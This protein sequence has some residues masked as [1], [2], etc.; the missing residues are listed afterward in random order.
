[1]L[2]EHR[3]REFAAA[4]HL[5]G[6]RAVGR[7]HADRHVAD[8][9]AVQTVLDHAG[10]ELVVLALR[11]GQRGVVDAEGHRDGRLVHV[12]Q[13]QR[14]RVGRVDDRL[15]DHDVVHAGDGHDV[16]GTG[17]L[18]REAVQTLGAQ[19]LGELEVLD[20]A[21]HT[22]QAVLLALDERAVVD[23]DQTQSAQVVRGVDVGHMGLQ[24]GALLVFG[25]GDVRDDRIEQRFQVVVVRQPAV[26]RLVRGGVAG[27]GGAV[28]HRQ[29]QQRVEVQVHAL[30]DHVLGQAEQQVGGLAHDLLDAGV[31]AVHLVH[32]QDHRQLGLQGLAQHEAGLR[33]R[34]LRGVD[35]QHHAVDHRDAA[36]D[37]A[38][39][40]GVTGGVDDVD[41]DAF[42][43]AVLLGERAGV[44]H[45]RVLRQDGDALLALQIVGIHH[46]V[47]DLLALG[48]HVRLLEHRVHQRGLAVIDVRHDRHISNI[49]TNCHQN[50]SYLISVA[51]LRYRTVRQT[52]VRPH[53]PSQV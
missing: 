36:L 10:G 39:E 28:D 20:R 18:D 48:E 49:A 47:G 42:G 11:A 37:L 3:Q 17:L 52:P 35:E 4:L 46:A 30:L 8:Q 14:L 32:A 2:G 24:R 38:A 26:L 34:A 27:L 43:M 16:A 19:D 44:L 25:G 53:K 40:V 29:V 50:L 13:R 9:L 31:R 21:A 45:R 23:A 7:Q 6:I 22:A 51:F 12:D 1:M 41:R 15:A 5:P 33:Q